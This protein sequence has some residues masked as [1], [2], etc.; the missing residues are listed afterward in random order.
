MKFNLPSS[1]PSGF[2]LIELLVVIAIIGILAAMLL[3]ALAQAKVKALEMSCLNNAKQISLANS[4]YVTDNNGSH[5]YNQQGG[6]R[7]PTWIDLITAN[8]S[9]SK[10]TRYCPATKNEDTN[11]MVGS[12]YYSPGGNYKFGTADY[13]WNC[14]NDWMHYD[15]RGSYGYNAYCY[16]DQGNLSIA[17]NAFPKDGSLTSPSKTPYFADAIWVDGWPKPNQTPPTDLYFGKDDSG[18][19]RFVIARHGGKPAAA[20]PRSYAGGIAGLPGRNNIGFA[21]GHAAGVR[22]RDYWDQMWSKEW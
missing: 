3:P 22:L 14:L 11:G 10:S 15:A 2:T 13:P 20:A 4:I 16:S 17:T 12:L 8:L 7:A 6:G 9:N 5:V 19:G 21:D 18:L 1:R